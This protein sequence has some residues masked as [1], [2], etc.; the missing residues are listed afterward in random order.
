MHQTVMV[1]SI[2]GYYLLQTWHVLSH[3][4]VH[5]RFIDKYL[6]FND[7]LSFSSVSQMYQ[8]AFCPC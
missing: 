1:Y 2:T 7:S 5:V 3:L 6:L 4:P 8:S